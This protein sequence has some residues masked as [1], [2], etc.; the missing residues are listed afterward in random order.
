M[1]NFFYRIA[2]TMPKSYSGW[3]HFGVILLSLVGYLIVLSNYVG[4]DPEKI[5]FWN[6]FKKAT[7]YLGLSYY[8]M[9]LAAK[10]F[11]IRLLRYG[12]WVVGIALI[13]MMIATLFFGEG[14]YGGKSWIRFGG[15]SIQPVEFVKIFMISLLGLY[16]ELIKHS[17]RHFLDMVKV[18]LIYYVVFAIITFLQKDLGSVVILTLIV[19]GLILCT[20]LEKFKV[21][22]IFIL[23]IGAI[24]LV[25]FF[26]CYTQIGIE[27]LSKIPGISRVAIRFQNTVNPFVDTV[28]A[29]YQSSN[30][31]YSIARGGIG[32]VGLGESIQKYGYLTQS[33]S[34]Y[35]LSILLEETGVWGFGL[36]V[37]GYGTILYRLFFYAFKA[38][39]EGFR[40]ILIGTAIY[41]FSHFFLNV[42]G[43]SGIVPLTGIPLLFISSGGSSLLATMIGIGI[44]QSVISTIRR[45]GSAQKRK[46]RAAS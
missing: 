31:L 28:S 27:V 18:P 3:I 36:V 5:D 8:M 13:M 4:G 32:G 1:K 34:D 15:F 20:T 12:H 17:K 43:V 9:C 29:G 16:I 41:I 6:E 26:F 19:V 2:P 21:L 30:G 22:Q 25:F 37:L 38:K 42:G 11:D 14:P 39:S 45:G 33:E 40:F 44:T 46:K 7:I 10:N 35:I 24:V 23:A